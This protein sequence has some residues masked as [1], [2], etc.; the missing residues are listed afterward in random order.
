MDPAARWS[1]LR[2]KS[3]ARFHQ[4]SSTL[5]FQPLL[6][7]IAMSSDPRENDCYGNFSFEFICITTSLVSQFEP[8]VLQTTSCPITYP[9]VPSSAFFSFSF[10][11]LCL[12][13]FSPSPFSF[14]SPHPVHLLLPPTFPPPPPLTQLLL[15]LA[16]V[17]LLLLLLIPS[18]TCGLTLFNPST[19]L[20]ILFGLF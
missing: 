2:G 3:E 18:H 1:S 13:P 7:C 20:S 6:Q 4:L 8:L 11:F 14:S 17:N 10:S 19:V 12:N 9:S 5:W 16:K 15:H